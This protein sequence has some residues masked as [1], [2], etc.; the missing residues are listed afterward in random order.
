[1]AFRSHQLLRDNHRLSIDTQAYICNVAS[2]AVI[3]WGCLTETFLRFLYLENDFL[4]CHD[5]FA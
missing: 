3:P 2:M 5:L 1:M 4:A